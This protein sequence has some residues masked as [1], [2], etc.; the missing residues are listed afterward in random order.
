MLPFFAV[1]FDLSYTLTAV[2]M[3]AALASS[4]LTQPL[5]GLW[6]DKRGALWLLPAGIGLA[7]AGDRACGRGSELRS[8]RRPRVPLGPRDRS[9]SS[10]GGEVRGLRKRAQAGERDV[11]LQHRG[12]HGLRARPDRRYA[13]RPLAR[14]RTRRPLGRDPGDP[15]LARRALGASVSLAPA[16]RA[17]ERRWCRCREGRRAGDGHPRRCDRA[18]QRRLVRV[19]DL[20]AA[21]GRVARELRGRR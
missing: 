2:L 17:T 12:Q 19:A 18:P 15:G 5:F 3:L 14:P 6:S 4:S 10:R 9:I 21:L 7:G 1:K 20:R 8:P 13:A 11:A 16:P